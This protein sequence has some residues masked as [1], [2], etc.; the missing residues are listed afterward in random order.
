M[1]RLAVLILQFQLDDVKENSRVILKDDNRMI[2][3]NRTAAFKR[4]VSTSK[5]CTCLVQQLVWKLRVFLNL[6]S[7]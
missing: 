5:Y 1:F 2:S 7:V 4:S 6:Q 3:D